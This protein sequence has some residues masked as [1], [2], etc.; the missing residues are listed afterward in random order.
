MRIISHRGQ[1]NSSSEKNTRKAFQNS[2]DNDY[3]IETDIRDLNGELVI[4]HDPPQ[5]SDFPMT[6]NTFISLL[7]ENDLP[8]AINIKS[9]GLA[10]ILK[11][12][13]ANYRGEWFT[14][15]MSGPETIRYI[16]AGIPVYCRHSDIETIPIFYDKC[17]GIWLDSFTSTIWYQEETI[18]SHLSNGKKVCVVSPELHKYD[19][20]NTWSLLKNSGLFTHKGLLLC[21][22]F[23]K[24]ASIYFEVNND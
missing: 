19:Y 24:K 23:P 12:K 17:S 21:T 5:Q 18:R 6:L 13:M 11:D 8:I 22:D 15:D 1:W 9:D 7:E 16:E 10:C 3:G 2:I 4:S 20:K 14:F